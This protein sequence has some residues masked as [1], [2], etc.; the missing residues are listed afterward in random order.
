MRSAISDS[1]CERR[2]QR[3]HRLVARP[4]PC[5]RPRICFWERFRLVDAKLEVAGE[6]CDLR[7]QLREKRAESREKKEE[8]RVRRVTPNGH[9]APA[10]ARMRGGGSQRSVFFT[11]RRVSSEL[12]WYLLLPALPSSVEANCFLLDFKD[13]L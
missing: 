10:E 3:E 5:V 1:S 4:P 7:L 11:L 13:F 12:L 8:R 2:E 9:V 6:K